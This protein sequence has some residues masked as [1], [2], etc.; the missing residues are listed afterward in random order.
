M[1]KTFTRYK[2]G[3]VFIT[4]GAIEMKLLGGQ[5]EETAD[6]TEAD[7]KEIDRLFKNPKDKVLLEKIRQRSKKDR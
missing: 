7:D 6:I 2:T 4:R 1:I 3:Q 5:V